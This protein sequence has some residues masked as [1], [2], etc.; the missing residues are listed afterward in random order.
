[1]DF[2]EPATVIGLAS[3]AIGAIVY[4]I[5]QFDKSHKSAMNTFIELIEKKDTNYTTFVNENNHKMTDQVKES[6]QTLV[7]VT[8]AIQ[9]HTMIL[10]DLREDL[11]KK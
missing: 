2:A 3:V 11:R 4:V 5:L 6:T 10:K 7:E 9:E 1:M 8:K